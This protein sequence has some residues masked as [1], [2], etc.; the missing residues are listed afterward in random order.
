V[1]CFDEETR[2]TKS[3]GGQ[4]HGVVSPEWNIG[5]NPNGGYLL[6]LI[7]SALS[8]EI[9]HPDPISITTHY[10]RPGLQD[11][12]YQINIDVIRVGRTLSNVRATLIQAG[13]P[14]LEVMAVYGDLSQSVGVEN[15]I[16]MIAPVIPAEPL[17]CDRTG[18]LQGIEL[19]IMN[20]LSVR[21]NPEQ[22]VSGESTEPVISGWIRFTDGREPDARSLLLFCDAFPPSPFGYLGNVGWVPTVELT[23]HVRQRPAVGWILG[24]FTTNH[25]AGGRMIESGALWD[26]TGSLV[27]QSRQLGL[28]LDKP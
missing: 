10:L 27:A 26:S 11:T 14:R 3:A 28:I 25:L 4:W 24:Q 16:P 2:A 22:S 19:P 23:V 15:E 13:K 6:S 1:Y 12:E 9:A 21:L 20:R 5:D 17:C 7:S 18:D 8:Q